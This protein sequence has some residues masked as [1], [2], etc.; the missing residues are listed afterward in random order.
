MNSFG[1]PLPGLGNINEMQNKPQCS[2]PEC[3]EISNCRLEGRDLCFKHS[4]II[5]SQM[6]DDSKAEMEKYEDMM[7]KMKIEQKKELENNKKKAQE[8]KEEEKRKALENA[9]N[10]YERMKIEFEENNFQV[11]TLLCNIDSDGEHKFYKITEASYLFEDKIVR[12]VD[13]RGN[14]KEESFYSKWRKD[15][16]K[17]K[18]E[19][20]GFYADIHK[21]PSYAYNMFKG[22]RADKLDYTMTEEQINEKV[23]PIIQLIDYLTGGFSSHLLKWLAKI[24]QDP[25]NKPEIL[26]LL[27][28][29][30]GLFMAAGGTGKNM[31]VEWFGDTII[32]DEYFYVISNNKEL[33]G[34]FNGLLESKI[35]IFIEEANG[36]DNHAQAEIIKTLITK[37]KMTVNNK[38]VNQYQAPYV[39][40]IIAAT[41][42]INAFPICQDDRRTWAFDVNKIKRGDSQYFKD[43]FKHLYNEETQYAFFQYLKNY[44]TY[45]AP[46]DFQND[47]PETSAYCQMRKMNAPVI[48]KWLGTLEV[49]DIIENKFKSRDLFNNFI[50]WCI[51]ENRNESTKMTLTNFTQQIKSSPSG[52]KISTLHG[53]TNIQ[54]IRNEIIENL[55]KFYVLDKDF[56]YMTKEERIKLENEQNEKDNEKESN[57]TNENGNGIYF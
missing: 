47:I 27:R 50:N 14:E 40:S 41:N 57:P 11:G 17:R 4:S 51:T 42:K 2:I 15:P 55:K 48:E 29:V 25:L 56:V 53:Y 36:T 13:K 7:K 26:V 5:L 16:K 52:F 1:I 43:T 8:I 21:C 49:L 9:A 24:I 20:V 18:Y 12:T 22:F 28:D 35:L 6:V 19:K 3:L 23:K 31:F 38:N 46:I 30:A 54:G 34:D 10:E 39:A 37:K 45:N 33:Y 32:G 44:K